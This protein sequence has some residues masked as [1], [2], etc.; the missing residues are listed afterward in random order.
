MCTQ[1]QFFYQG[2]SHLWLV[3]FMDAESMDMEDWLRI[4]LCWIFSLAEDYWVKE[5]RIFLNHFPKGL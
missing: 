4:W 3:E 1:M 2:T 5:Y